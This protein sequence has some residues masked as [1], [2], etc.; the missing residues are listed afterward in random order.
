MPFYEKFQELISVVI[1]S[2]KYLGC[3]NVFPEQYDIQ[4]SVSVRQVV[5]AN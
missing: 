5:A 1:I 4:S 3:V 2:R